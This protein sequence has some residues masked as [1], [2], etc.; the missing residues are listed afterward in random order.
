MLMD[1]NNTKI[2]CEKLNNL[3]DTT[4]KSS[5]I[6]ECTIHVESI[7]GDFKWSKKYGGRTLDSIMNIASITKLFTT[8]C[9][10][11]LIEQ[12]KLSFNDKLSKFF[13]QEILGGIH[14]YKGKDY[15]DE[16][17]VGNLL[18][19]NTGIP[20]VFAAENNKLNKKMRHEDFQ[21]SFEE[22][23]RIAKDNKKKF[24]PGTAGKAHYSD[25]H[26]EMLGK[27][28]EQLEA[29]SL[30]DAFKKYAFRPLGLHNTYLME[31]ENDYCTD[32]YYKNKALHL[33]NLWSNLPGSGGCMSTSKEI[34]IFLKAFFGGE[35]FNKRIF[36]Q[37]K[38][39]AMIQY[40]PP[41]GQY[42]GGFVRL[43]I[44]GIAS[45]YQVK[46]ELI[47]HMGGCGTFAYY[48]PEKNLFFVGDVNQFAKPELIFT[49]P[50]K[51]AKFAYKYL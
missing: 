19:Q 12:G 47:G 31:T 24:A 11:N 42:C 15:S 18:F 5:M 30:H 13:G 50:L 25:L 51:I 26:F 6:H 39:P 40:A 2:F 32:M 45:V 17:T 14:I 43:N 7:D 37:L 21:V 34:M 10:I 20:D 9:I 33:P 44:S 35:L 22:Y 27:I 4:T 38:K 8:T 49:L 29:S 1:N 46:G 23:I 41:L 16:L 48:Y 3:F 36:E 28:I